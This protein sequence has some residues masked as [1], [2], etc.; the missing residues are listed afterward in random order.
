LTKVKKDEG[1][2]GEFYY[3][4]KRVS[5]EEAKTIHELFGDSLSIINKLQYN[6][7]IDN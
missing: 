2:K 6:L 1:Y 5:G 3:T 7:K 4:L